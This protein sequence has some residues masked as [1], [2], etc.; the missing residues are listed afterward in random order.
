VQGALEIEAPSSKPTFTGESAAAC[1]RPPP[2]AVARRR[3]R[4][5]VRPEPL[6]LDLALL[7][8]PPTDHRQPPSDLESSQ[9]NPA[10]SANFAE[11]PLRFLIFTKIPFCLRKFLAV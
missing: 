3:K 8:N 11:N 7:L 10:G 6:D 5:R 2:L 1:C 4:A 9:S